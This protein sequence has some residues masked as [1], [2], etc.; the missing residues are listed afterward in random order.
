MAMVHQL[1]ARLESCRITSAADP[2]SRFV[3]EIDGCWLDARIREAP[4]IEVYI[5][6]TH[7]PGMRLHLDARGAIALNLQR[8]RVENQGYVHFEYR[9]A[10][11]AQALEL[12]RPAVSFAEHVD[13]D[14]DRALAALWLDEPA[15]AA[16]VDAID[17]QFH[18]GAFGTYARPFAYD[19]YVERGEVLVTRSSELDLDFLAR[20][21]RAGAML[22]ARPHRIA[23]AWH[24]L[25][26]SFGGTTTVD[27][28]DLAEDFAVTIDR[29][30]VTVQIDN[31]VDGDRFLTRMR[32]RRIGEAAKAKLSSGDRTLLDDAAPDDHDLDA[33]PV[34]LTWRGIVMDPAR[35][36]PGIELC[37]RLAGPRGEAHG[38]YR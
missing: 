29:G 20:A 36:G 14:G 21:V 3:F 17:L 23:R 35:L 38:P 27:R 19:T 7:V 30:A 5:R 12:A 31:V 34:T 37:A 15:R 9:E 6:T 25:A 8:H 16:F 18:D 26:R 1:A 28:W 22:A 13:V 33:D 32:A 10:D 11:V 4:R 2:Q 24:E